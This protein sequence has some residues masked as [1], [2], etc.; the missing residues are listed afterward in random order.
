ML[1]I[2][3]FDNDFVRNSTINLH[4]TN[5]QLILQ[6]NSAGSTKMHCNPET[7]TLNITLHSYNNY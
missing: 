7:I 1:S 4:F 2:S 5:K 6:D 3:L